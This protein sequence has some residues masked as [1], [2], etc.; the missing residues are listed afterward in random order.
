MVDYL[1]SNVSTDE[2]RASLKKFVRHRTA[3][4][5]QVGVGAL[6]GSDSRNIPHLGGPGDATHPP[7]PTPGLQACSSG[8]MVRVQS[9]LERSCP[10]DS[11]DYD[12]RTGLM[13]AAVKGHVEVAQ[14]R[15]GGGAPG[16][17]SRL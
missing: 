6:G 3:D 4:L 1:E 5:L 9:L 13:L 15:G 12:N 8:D 17:F 2:Q 11:A 16:S 10:P 14:V 7:P